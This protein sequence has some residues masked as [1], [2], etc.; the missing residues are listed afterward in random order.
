MRTDNHTA[1]AIHSKNVAGVWNGSL[2]QCSAVARSVPLVF[3]RQPLHSEWFAGTRDRKRPSMRV[4][5]S[6]LR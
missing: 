4:G 6:E 2:R 3:R 1:I 5:G